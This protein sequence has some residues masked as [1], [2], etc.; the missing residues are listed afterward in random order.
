MHLDGG[1][2]TLLLGATVPLPAKPELLRSLEQVQ[3]TV[4]QDEA[5][6]F[7]I[8]FRAARVG[9]AA[10][11]D[12]PLLRSSQLKPFNRVVIVVTLRAQPHVLM[13]GVITDIQHQPA[14]GAQ[15]GLITVTGED[16]TVLMD[17]EERQ[18]EHACLNAPAIVMQLLLKYARYGVLPKVAPVGATA[19][20]SLVE[21][22]PVQC[23]TDL[24]YIQLLARRAGFVFFLSPGPVPGT[25]TAY[26]GPPPRIGLPQ[27]A[28]T[29][30]MGTS[31]N[32]ESIDFRVDSLGPTPLAGY[33]QDPR[34]GGR[35]ELASK[36]GR[37]PPLAKDPAAD[38]ARKHGRLRRFRESGLTVAEAQARMNSRFGT[39][40]TNAVVGNGQLNAL[41]YGGVL[42][43]RKLVGVRGVG[44][45]HDGLYLVTQVTHTLQRGSYTQSFTITREGTGTTTPVVRV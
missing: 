10:F 26:W 35:R 21:R 45:T 13:D 12:Y 16:L 5:S 22:I 37:E 29:A 19:P 2:L 1:Y 38:I 18:K 14:Q 27:K 30:N 39:S 40:A 43:A 8:R 15:A 31:S 32:V 23:E 20:P 7:Q 3:V 42:Q 9:P 25:S 11:E 6:G 17:M 33:V 36:S 4:S 44:R 28:L 41:A 34:T 24:E